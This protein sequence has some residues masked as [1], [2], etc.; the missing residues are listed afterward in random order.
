MPE[1]P[2]QMVDREIKM[3]TEDTMLQWEY[4]ISLKNPSVNYI[5][6]ESLKDTPLTKVIMYW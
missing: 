5:L 3:L 6:C 1:L 2:W 4:Y